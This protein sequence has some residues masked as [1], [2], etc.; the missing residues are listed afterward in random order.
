MACFFPRYYCFSNE[1]DKFRLLCSSF[2]KISSIRSRNDSTFAYVFL[3]L[4]PLRM[5][6]YVVVVFL[7]SKDYW[8]VACDLTRR[9]KKVDSREM[10][11]KLTG[12]KRVR[13]T[14]TR[15]ED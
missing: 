3:L 13:G 15:K 12:E 6:F 1:I 9:E 5:I 4:D 2:D 8:S 14:C 10:N 7:L 11:K